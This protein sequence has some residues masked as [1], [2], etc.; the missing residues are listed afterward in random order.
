MADPVAR[1]RKML[2]DEIEMLRMELSS[3][4]D[5]EEAAEIAAELD[6]AEGSLASL[7]MCFL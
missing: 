1:T 4:S 6:R 3:V 7:D 2:R 5:P